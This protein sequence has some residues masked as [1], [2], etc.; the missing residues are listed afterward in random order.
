MESWLI[1]GLCV[2][3]RN[4]A[5][6][7]ICPLRNNVFLSYVIFPVDM[8]DM[9][10]R[11]RY[12]TSPPLCDARCILLASIFYI[13]LTTSFAICLLIL[14]YTVDIVLLSAVN[15]F[16]FVD[17]ILYFESRNSRSKTW[18]VSDM[19]AECA[20]RKSEGDFGAFSEGQRMEC[21]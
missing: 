19:F 20:S 3:L 4:H 21:T 13:F 14:F 7:T 2:Q 17:T 9:S 5:G 8:L 12:F 10:T 6:I 11:V 18:S 1:S 16:F 15:T